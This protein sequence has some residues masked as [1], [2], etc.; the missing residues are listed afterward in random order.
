VTVIFTET[1]LAGAWTI[2]L[3]RREDPRGFFARAWCQEEFAQHGLE[4]RVVQ[5]NLSHN[6]RRGT[7]RGMHYQVPPHAEV[8]VVRCT[9]GS[10]YDVIVDLRPESPSYGRWIGVELSAEN[11]RALYVPEG[12]A[13]GYQAL[14]DETETYYQVSEFYAPGA[15]RG[16]RWDDPAFAITWPLPDDAFLSEKDRTWPDFGP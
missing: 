11:G 5:C 2:D 10:V 12:F 3:D 8:K 13:H 9:R 1:E 4:T 16:L 7:V 15:E 14:E 6:E